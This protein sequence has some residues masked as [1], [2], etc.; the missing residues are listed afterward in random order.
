VTAQEKLTSVFMMG[1]CMHVCYF[2]YEPGLEP[3]ILARLSMVLSRIRYPISML[4]ST[5]AHSVTFRVDSG[6]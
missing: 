2:P 1:C 4:C 3:D 5:M 6:E